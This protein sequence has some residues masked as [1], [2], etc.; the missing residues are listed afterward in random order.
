MRRLEVQF[1]DSAD[2]EISFDYVVKLVNPR[3]IPGVFG[4]FDADG[5]QNASGLKISRRTQYFAEDL[6]SPTVSY[7][8]PEP[9]ATGVNDYF[10]IFLAGAV[11]SI[12]GWL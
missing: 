2:A 3:K 8:N 9:V 1:A 5:R 7:E 6:L 11:I 12:G 10:A 4:V